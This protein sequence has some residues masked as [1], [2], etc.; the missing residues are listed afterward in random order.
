MANIEL[1]SQDVAL[2]GNNLKGSQSFG[3][4]TI[5]YDLD[6]SVPQ[7]SVNGSVFG[8]SIGH[9]VLNKDQSSATLGGNVGIAKAEVKITADF[10][11]KEV[12]YSV[13]V[14]SFVKTIYKG[15]GTLF[16]W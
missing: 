7:L 10:D 1:S 8:T 12:D 9:V 5:N 15:S 3:P 14:E 2:L 11:T 6:I 13:D 4:L 16:T